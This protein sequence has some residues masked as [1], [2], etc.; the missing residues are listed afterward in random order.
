MIRHLVRLVAAV[1]IISFGG[2]CDR[3]QRT[4]P[5]RSDVP[6]E[7]RLLPGDKAVLVQM[8]LP[9]R[10]T[11]TGPQESFDQEI[12]RLRR[13]EITALVRV[14]AA[15]GEIA[16]RGTW[17]RTRVS[18]EL[19]RLVKA[20]EGSALGPAI[21]FTYSAGT[22]R[23]GNVVVTTGKFPRFVEG[24][25]YLVFLRIQ[26]GTSASLVWDGI[27][28]R[29]DA[30]GALQRVAISDGGEQSFRTNLVGRSVSDVIEALT[31]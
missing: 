31:P 9:D 1:G 24:E 20:R 17:V 12:Q 7:G 3:S 14:T 5:Y 2:G 28:F 25:Q 10:K 21:E 23:I 11:D 26:Q 6:I 4:I 19:D 18:A 13:G 16:D 15:T 30:R 29:V 8:E 22:A 27:G